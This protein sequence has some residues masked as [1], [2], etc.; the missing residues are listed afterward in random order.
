MSSAVLTVSFAC[1]VSKI[2][3]LKALGFVESGGIPLFEIR[4]FIVFCATLVGAA[5]GCGRDGVVSATIDSSAFLRSRFI[6]LADVRPR[7][8]RQRRR[9]V[10]GVIGA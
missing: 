6:R 5:P 9:G 10:L 3:Q 1:S 2:A 7:L 4:A 8:R